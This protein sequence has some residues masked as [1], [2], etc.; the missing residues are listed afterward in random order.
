M[1]E[2]GQDNWGVG[3]SGAAGYRR[4]MGPSE[5]PV[6]V[7][8]EAEIF[9]NSLVFLC[10]SA[11]TSDIARTL[12]G[13]GWPL[14]IANEGDNAVLAFVK[15]G[16]RVVVADTLTVA[17]DLAALA[18][19]VESHHGALLA[20]VVAQALDTAVAA[21]ATHVLSAPFT[22]D[23]LLRAVALADRHAERLRRAGQA[24]PPASAGA[25]ESGR[26][27][28]TG[29]R[30]STAARRWIEARQQGVGSRFHIL[31]LAITR[32]DAIN[33][34]FGRE[35][36][37]D[38]LRT[39]A[40][41]IAPVVTE[42]G[43][44]NA[45]IARATGAEFIVG[46]PDEPDRLKAVG[47][48]ER[49]I[50]LVERPIASHAHLVT[51]SPRIAVAASAPGD[52]N[53]APLLRRASRMLADA[54][55]T[56]QTRI[57]VAEDEDERNEALQSD[58]RNALARD[59][60]EML[61]QPQVSVT[62]GK[63]VGVE[64]LARWRHPEHGSLGAET[65]FA[66]AEQ[67][68][69]LLALSTHIQQRAL[70]QAAAWPKSLSGLR[71]AVNIT[72]QDIARAGFASSFLETVDAS[73]FARSRLTVEVT[74]TGLIAD[75]GAAATLLAEL[76]AGGCRVAIDDFGTGYSSLTYLKALPLDYLKI[77][78][79]LA[80]DIAGSTR[81]RIVVRGVIDMA[82]SLGLAVVAEGVETEEQLTLLAREG[83]NY[84]QGFLCAEPLSVVALEQ[85]VA[86]RP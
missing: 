40:R 15:S 16:A 18:E 86:D 26:D 24:A 56:E 53:A 73:G 14:A 72:A 3:A 41:V 81:D 78:Q 75:L 82:R 61:F 46:L 39:V 47:L 22:D 49:M 5:R 32:F 20:V 43:G 63:I 64:A 65:L 68:D 44:P 60:I 30:D 11:R 67:S 71:L 29:L 70:A 35:T 38:L 25:V 34:A 27:P 59:E 83:C 74:E 13:A 85:V 79:R 19:A 66:V 4:P 9:L 8:A 31:M 76:R 17:A 23:E 36:G 62:T 84:Y 45:L 48:A 2:W 52:A 6:D 7:A 54:E 55:A 50:A 33:T 1:R 42:I 10:G 58:L 21:G 80:Q 77:D 57:R 28:L 12:D 37:D 51:L 69:Y